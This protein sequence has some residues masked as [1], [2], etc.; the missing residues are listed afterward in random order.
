MNLLSASQGRFFPT[1]THYL[2]VDPNSTS[3]ERVNDPDGLCDRLEPT[4]S[5]TKFALVES[6]KA[7]GRM[8][9]KSPLYMAFLSYEIS[10]ICT[11][12]VTGFAGMIVGAVVGSL[13]IYARGCVGTEVKRFFGLENCKLLGECLTTGFHRGARLGELPG[14]LLGCCAVFLLSASLVSSGL[15]LPAM[16]GF[17]GGGGSLCALVTFASIKCCGENRIAGFTEN[18]FQIFFTVQQRT[19]RWLQGPPNAQE[20]MFNFI[21]NWHTTFKAFDRSKM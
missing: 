3:S 20:E 7:F 14:K 8:V 4:Q 16:V 1:D 19:H 21:E 9:Y 6:A 12:V 11:E 18:F 13:S 10:R 2:S 15:M 5:N 17:A